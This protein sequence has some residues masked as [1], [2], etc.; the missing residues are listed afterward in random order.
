MSMPA[1][2]PHPAATAAG[3][4]TPRRPCSRP[5][6]ARGSSVSPDCDRE[7]SGAAGFSDQP[8]ATRRSVRL[9]ELTRVCPSN[10]ARR[11][12]CWTCGQGAAHAAW[13]RGRSAL[14]K[15]GGELRPW[16][17]R[18]LRAVLHARGRFNSRPARQTAKSLQ[19]PDGSSEGWMGPGS[20]RRQPC[21][22]SQ[23]SGVATGG[24]P[25][26][27]GRLRGWGAGCSSGSFN[28]I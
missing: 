19:A 8:P 17:L 13:R 23:P 24:A 10:D 22:R 20:A 4:R 6:G 26:R 18:L 21:A 15:R 5:R 9:S 12:G 14:S 27:V 16:P 25:S 2:G 1:T 11:S 7:S 3:R 28:V